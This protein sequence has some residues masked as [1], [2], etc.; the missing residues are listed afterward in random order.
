MYVVMQ[1]GTRQYIASEGNTIDIDKID[2]DPGEAV[3]FDNI[4]LINS[5]DKITLG[6]PHIE[7]A[8][9]EATVETHLRDKK[10]LA[11]RYKNK[12]R[13]GTKRGHRQHK[14][15]ILINKINIGQKKTIKKSTENK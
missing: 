5:K 13:S 3:T 4:L 1:I 9:V 11:F 2:K 12:T 14:T 6:K 7:G 10:V 15:K 8:K